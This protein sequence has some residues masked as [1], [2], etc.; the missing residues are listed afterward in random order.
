[1]R[2]WNL[3]CLFL[4]LR[5][6][7]SKDESICVPGHQDGITAMP[8]DLVKRRTSFRMDG[9]NLRRDIPG[10][11]DNRLRLLC[12]ECFRESGEVPKE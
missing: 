6:I 11:P 9:W 12:E 3:I 10:I 2:V 8:D 1:M 4:I 7:S 5:I